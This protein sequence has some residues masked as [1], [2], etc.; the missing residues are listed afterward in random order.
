MNMVGN[1][2]EGLSRLAL[3][4]TKVVF[5]TFGGRFRHTRLRHA[6]AQHP[7][8]QTTHATLPKVPYPVIICSYLVVTVDIKMIRDLKHIY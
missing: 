1:G 3:S 4:N 5:P 6:I 8:M 7:Q 2:C